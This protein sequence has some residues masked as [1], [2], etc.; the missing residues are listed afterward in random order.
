MRLAA[1]MSLYVWSMAVRSFVSVLQ[2]R[3][4]KLRAKT[5]AF[6]LLLM[7]RKWMCAWWVRVIKT[8]RFLMRSGSMDWSSAKRRVQVRRL[9]N[10]SS[11][12]GLVLLVMGRVM[13][14]ECVCKGGELFDERLY[15]GEEVADCFV[16]VVLVVIE[17]LACFE[18][19]VGGGV[20][21]FVCAAAGGVEL[22]GCG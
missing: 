13:L 6:V 16:V 17:E 3:Q 2:R 9:L 12:A 22:L 20:Q 7:M 8:L 14:F 11:C 4:L 15:D 18:D 21:D 5:M 19:A 1:M 10:S